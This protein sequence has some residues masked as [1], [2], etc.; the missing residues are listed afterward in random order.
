[1]RAWRWLACAS[2]LA[3]A[4]CGDGSP[5]TAL[6]VVH[7]SADAP[8]IDVFVDGEGPVVSGLAF[9]RGSDAVH[10]AP[11]DRDTL[12]A[13]AGEGAGSAVVTLNSADRPYVAII[14]CPVAYV[15][16]SD[17]ELAR[18]TARVA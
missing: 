16:V 15:Y 2:L 6:R 17:A 11:G 5:E 9:A 3:L 4:S 13:A 7:L 18:E 14:E 10:V 1:M 8:R 12:V